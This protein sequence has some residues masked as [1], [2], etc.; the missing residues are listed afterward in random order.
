MGGCTPVAGSNPI[1]PAKD[2]SFSS[3]QI[4]VLNTQFLSRKIPQKKGLSQ[5]KGNLQKIS[6]KQKEKSFWKKKERKKSGKTTHK[7]E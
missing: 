4:F 5:K 2:G 1:R 7:I 6:P 3:E